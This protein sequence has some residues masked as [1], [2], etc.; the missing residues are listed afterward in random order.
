M[1]KKNKL[2]MALVNECQKQ[3]KEELKQ[4]YETYKDKFFDLVLTIE[5]ELG[6]GREYLAQL[7]KDKELT[8][9]LIEQEGYVRAMKYL[10]DLIQ[11][12]YETK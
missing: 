4:E 2:A 5:T 1:D 6:N 10:K 3:I 8:F 11:E 12:N 7:K 9:N